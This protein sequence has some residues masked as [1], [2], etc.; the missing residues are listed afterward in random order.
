MSLEIIVQEIKLFGN[1]LGNQ[2]N[3]L[4]KKQPI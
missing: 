2:K 3:L 4:V 1:L